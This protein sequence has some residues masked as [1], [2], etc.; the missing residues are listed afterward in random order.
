MYIPT[1]YPLYF[2]TYGNFCPCCGHPMGYNVYQHN[3]WTVYGQVTSTGQ[4][5]QNTEKKEDK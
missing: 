3:P 4:P 1:N 5:I 2:H